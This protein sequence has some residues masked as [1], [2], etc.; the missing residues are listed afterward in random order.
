MRPSY[1]H[2]SLKQPGPYRIV[3]DFELLTDPSE[4]PPRLVQV[5][6][7][8]RVSGADGWRGGIN[9]LCPQMGTDG[10]AV[11]AESLSQLK[12]RCPGLVAPHQLV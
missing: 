6:D 10:S 5:N 1:P 12:D 3:A 11:D 4:R 2:P 7:G 9:A 8:G